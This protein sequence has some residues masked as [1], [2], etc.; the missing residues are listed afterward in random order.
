MSV[1]DTKEI[2]RADVNRDG[3]VNSLD[4]Q[5]VARHFNQR[6]DWNQPPPPPPPPSDTLAIILNDMAPTPHEGVICGVVGYDW[7][8][9]AAIQRAQSGG[10]PAMTGW[11]VAQH[12]CGGPQGYTG[13]VHVRN[14]QTWLWNGSAYTKVQSGAITWHD[15]YNTQTSAPASGDSQWRDEG[16]GE[17]S[18]VVPADRSVHWAGPNN[19]IP[20]TNFWIICTAEYKLVG[21]DIPNANIIADVGADWRNPGPVGAVVGRY[22]K[23]TDQWQLVTATTFRPGVAPV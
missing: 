15:T 6:S 3:I 5:I 20:A 22:H 17:Y 16:N 13:R 9:H 10:I 11:G 18:F 7:E 8:H 14:R 1:D 19:N 23:L 21:G 2:N 4:L 12:G